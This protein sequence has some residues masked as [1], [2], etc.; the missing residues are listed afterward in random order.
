M[1]RE[2]FEAEV[3][4]FNNPVPVRELGLT[5]CLAPSNMCI[6]GPDEGKASGNGLLLPP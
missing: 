3:Q 5:A 1:A 6:V 2:L 4:E